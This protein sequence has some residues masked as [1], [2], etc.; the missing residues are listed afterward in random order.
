MGETA[1]GPLGAPART[2][3]ASRESK[4][5]T[6][7][8]R[9][10][11]GRTAALARRMGRRRRLRALGHVPLQGGREAGRRPSPVTAAGAGVVRVDGAAG[12]GAEAGGGPGQRP[13]AIV[14]VEQG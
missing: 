13:G 11:G 14:D 3:E 2:G 4:G 9:L 8:P 12:V 5:S 10:L 6:S 1:R 7:L